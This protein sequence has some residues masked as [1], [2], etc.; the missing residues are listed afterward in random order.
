MIDFH[1][2]AK[3][4]PIMSSAAAAGS[5]EEDCPLCLNPMT[6]ADILFPLFCPNSTCHFN[7]CANCI[8]GMQKSEADGYQEA[9][10][11]SRQVKFHIACPSSRMKYSA[12]QIMAQP[13]LE[14]EKKGDASN[15]PSTKNLSSENQV[16]VSYVLLLREAFSA[17]KL[18]AMQDSDLSSTELNKKYA[19][20]QDTTLDDVKE[21]H[22]NYTD[23]LQKIHKASDGKDVPVFDWENDFQLLP[24]SFEGGASKS[25][26]ERRQ[27]RLTAKPWRDPSLFLGLDEL[28][29]RQEQEY[30]TQLLCNNDTN[31]LAQAAHILYGM[32]TAT[33]RTQQAVSS[34]GNFGAPL[35]RSNGPPAPS[36]NP[37]EMQKIKGRFP[38]PQHMPRCVLIPVFDVQSSERKHPLKFDS[39]ANFPLTLSQVRGVAGRSGLRRGDIVTHID[40][41]PVETLDDFAQNVHNAWND[42]P[43]GD[44]MIVV[45]AHPENAQALRER[46]QAM[47]KAKVQ[48]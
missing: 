7:M 41:E 4:I 20:I 26:I 42:N 39:T 34:M 1:I 43:Q 17:V 47:Q 19:F 35:K 27:E 24:R 36:V 31:N 15:L 3:N 5:E 44:L 12:H 33:T 11:G 38:L 18:L 2:L 29:T 25:A 28:M 48:F 14:E 23:Y 40:A 8:V 16:V 46:A 6:E 10:D 22:Y 30:V 45:N 9:S 37:K 21:A 32:L 13:S